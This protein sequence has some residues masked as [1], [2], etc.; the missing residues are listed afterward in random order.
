MDPLFAEGFQLMWLGMG[1]VFVFLFLLVLITQTMS[2]FIE[3]FFPLSLDDGME[4]DTPAPT[5]SSIP[6]QHLAAI[7]LAIA[8]HRQRQ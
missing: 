4:Q 7:K 6:P 8:E 3:R 1:T 2:W 5:A